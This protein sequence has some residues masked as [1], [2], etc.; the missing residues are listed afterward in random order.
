M[1]FIEAYYY[2]Y[3]I[4]YKAW[5]RNNN[6]FFSN[7]FSTDISFT[8]LKI[9]IVMIFY[10]YLGVIL[11]FRVVLSIT[12][13]EGFIPVILAFASTSYFF[14]FSTKWK[15]YF[16]NFEK[17]PRKKK[18]I[19]SLIVWSIIAF[20]VINLFISVDMMKKNGV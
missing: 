1:T 16:E 5:G 10:A 14:T 19:G 15:P 18:I 11:H 12:K 17:W 8:V 6:P 20:I 13:P 9:W 4:I 7:S 2:F 3:Y